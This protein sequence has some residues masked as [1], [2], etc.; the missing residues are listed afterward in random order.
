MPA[1]NEEGTIGRVIDEVREHA[2][3]ADIAVIDDGSTDRTASRARERGACVVNLPFNLGYGAALQTGFRLAAMEGYEFVITIDADGQHI[4]ACMQSLIE[5]RERHDADV[6][7]G[8]RFYTGAYRVGLAKRI[9]IWLFSLIG[10]MYTG[11]RITDPTS[12]FQLLRRRAFVF[13][14]EGDNYP[15][16]YPDVNIIMAL[17][18]MHYRVVEA[19]VT[20]REGN[21]AKSM[22]RGMKPV[23]YVARMCLAI[24][25]VLLR[26]GS[27]RA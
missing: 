22:H 25:M 8:S 1:F 24:F 27:N 16:D 10:K 7:I 4:P 13:L 3:F 9:G 18:K 14:S 17:H 26:R 5:A 21:G 6:V 2:P 11:L 20:M 12:G 19:P 23:I 15:H